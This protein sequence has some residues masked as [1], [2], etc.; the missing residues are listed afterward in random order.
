[1]PAPG[2]TRD[3]LF[4]DDVRLGILAGNVSVPRGTFQPLLNPLNVGFRM[5]EC[6]TTVERLFYTIG[7]RHIGGEGRAYETGIPPTPSRSRTSRS[8]GTRGRAHPLP[9]AWE[10][11]QR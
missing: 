9:L 1:M 2:E 3:S 4:A 8:C 7:K 11:R 5:P 10:E 6:L